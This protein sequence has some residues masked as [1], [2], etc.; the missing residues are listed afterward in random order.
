[1]RTN[2]RVGRMVQGFT[3][4]VITVSVAAGLMACRP[5]D[6]PSSGQ[7]TAVDTAAILAAIDSLGAIVE[8][9]DET[10]DAELYASTWTEDAVI[11]MP[12]SPPVHGRD[13]IVADFRRRP[14]FPRGARFTIHPGEIRILSGEWA[15]VFG[16]DSLTYTPERAAE[17][18]AETSTFLVLIRKTPEG[19][20]GYREVIGANQR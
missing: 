5:Q 17:P 2:D 20:Q 4:V 15:Y 16:V 12:G 6:Q 8:R 9:A 10:G 3:P 14:P 1:M 7:S 19:W 18:V 11:S 13:A